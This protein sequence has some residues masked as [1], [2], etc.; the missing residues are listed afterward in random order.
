MRVEDHPRQ[1]TTRET[2]SETPRHPHQPPIQE[3]GGG[4]VTP[5]ADEK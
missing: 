4:W 5:S 1:Q 3:I 2:T